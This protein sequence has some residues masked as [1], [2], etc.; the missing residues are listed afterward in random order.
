MNTAEDSSR[1]QSLLVTDRF[2]LVHS[3][4]NCRSEATRTAV[5]NVHVLTRNCLFA[6]QSDLISLS[7]HT[8]VASQHL[9]PE[10]VPSVP[11]SDWLKD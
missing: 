5:S 9:F 11:A 6:I 7:L 8:D 3:L 1:L 10:F 2:V 4:G